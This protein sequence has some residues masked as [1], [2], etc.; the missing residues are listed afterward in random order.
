MPKLL[1]LTQFFI[2]NQSKSY[3]N[4]MFGLSFKLVDF[5]QKIK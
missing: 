3:I 5:N 1:V 2:L 4:L